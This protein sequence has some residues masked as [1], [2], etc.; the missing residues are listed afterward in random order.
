MK[1]LKLFGDYAFE[2]I[3][4]TVLVAISALTVIFF[5]PVTVGVTGYFKNAA[6]RTYS[7]P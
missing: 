6:S 4:V 2:F 5:V 7:S 1:G 3:V